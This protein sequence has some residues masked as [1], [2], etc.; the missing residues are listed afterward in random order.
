M[1]KNAHYT[2]ESAWTEI[3]KVKSTYNQQK[4]IELYHMAVPFIE[5]Y[6]NSPVTV[7]STREFAVDY[8][9]ILRLILKQSAGKKFLLSFIANP[10]TGIT[11]SLSWMIWLPTKVGSHAAMTVLRSYEA[12]LEL[13][14]RGPIMNHIATQTDFDDPKLL[15]PDQSKSVDH[16][17]IPDLVPIM[18]QSDSKTKSITLDDTAATSGVACNTDNFSS[19]DGETDE[20]MAQFLEQSLN[21]ETPDKPVLNSTIPMMTPSATKARRPSGPRKLTKGSR[22]QSL[23]DSG[24]N[25]TSM[26]AWEDSRKARTVNMEPAEN[27]LVDHEDEIEEIDLT[28]LEISQFENG[29]DDVFDDSSDSFVQIPS[30][31]E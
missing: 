11:R 29:P 18:D 24:V 2:V 27:I 5:K 26:G 4:L 13:Q 1:G 7:L 3:S 12:E 14:A 28:E 8:L 22:R 17:S 20:I 19:S 23:K 6:D 21:Q 9:P 10:W 16:S 15:V 30:D 31:A 25:L